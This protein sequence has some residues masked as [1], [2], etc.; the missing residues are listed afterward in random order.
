MGCRFREKNL[1]YRVSFRARLLLGA[2]WLVGWSLQCASVPALCWFL[3][4]YLVCGLG[5]QG[6]FCPQS[7]EGSTDMATNSHFLASP[8]PFPKALD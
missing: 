8:P 2:E 5:H 3:P 7:S 4:P 1:K 6:V